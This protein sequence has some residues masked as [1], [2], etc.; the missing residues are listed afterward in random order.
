MNQSLIQVRKYDTI[1][2]SG[3]TELL[4]EIKIG[5]SISIT[6]KIVGQNYH[7]TTLLVLNMCTLY[8]PIYGISC[9]IYGLAMND[10]G[11]GH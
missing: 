7:R 10:L 11:T 4:V 6:E 9:D 2:Y 8:R 5:K 3:K 1:E